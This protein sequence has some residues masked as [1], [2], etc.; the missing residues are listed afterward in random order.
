MV[1]VDGL[2]GWSGVIQRQADEARA[3]DAKRLAELEARLPYEKEKLNTLDNE[4]LLALYCQHRSAGFMTV[5]KPIH[6]E[7]TEACE[8]LIL[9]RMGTPKG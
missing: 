4:T 8:M 5:F 3:A 6:E 1:A 7:M 9:A 2:G